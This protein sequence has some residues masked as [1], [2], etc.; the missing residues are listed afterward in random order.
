MRVRERLRVAVRA[1]ESPVG[2]LKGVQAHRGPW[3]AFPYNK[4]ILTVHA[5]RS[6]VSIWT[7]AGRAAVNRPKRPEQCRSSS[8]LLEG[9]AHGFSRGS[10]TRPML[11]PARLNRD[12]FVVDEA[13][14]TVRLDEH[15]TPISATSTWAL[16]TETRRKE[17][18]RRPPAPD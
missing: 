17:F 18:T 3:G 9:Q 8:A 1:G 5:D 16:R 11:S 7:V 14:S 4:R 6:K 12:A 2:Y 15:P 10:L 13:E